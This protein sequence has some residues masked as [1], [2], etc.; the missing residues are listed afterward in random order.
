M[1]VQKGGPTQ[2]GNIMTKKKARK[3]ESGKDQ[4]KLEETMHH[5]G[6]K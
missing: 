6:N 4:R 3:E 1:Q 5:N 2:S